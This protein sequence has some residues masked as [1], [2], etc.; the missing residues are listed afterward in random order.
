M[1]F[2]ILTKDGGLSSFGMIGSVGIQK[3]WVGGVD[4]F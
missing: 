2:S 4:L 1:A 3:A